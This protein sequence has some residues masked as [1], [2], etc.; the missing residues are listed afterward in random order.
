M[1]ILMDK[2]KIFIFQLVFYWLRLE[3]ELIISSSKIKIEVAWLYSLSVRSF[4]LKKTSL[5]IFTDIYILLSVPVAW[6]YYS[7]S[8]LKFFPSQVKVVEK[9]IYF[10]FFPF[11]LNPP[12][13]NLLTFSNLSP[14]LNHNYKYHILSCVY[15][16]TSISSHW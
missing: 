1:W 12:F 14:T 4:L 9:Y 11:F 10:M 15:N 6:L 2:H 13:F 5:K 7:P 16:K 8:K 3:T